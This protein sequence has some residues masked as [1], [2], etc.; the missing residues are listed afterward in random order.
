MS[1]VV[2]VNDLTRYGLRRL[3]VMRMGGRPDWQHWRQMV[4]AAALDSLEYIERHEPAIGVEHLE[5]WWH[6]REMVRVA[7]PPG[8][9]MVGVMWYVER[10]E[11]LS[12]AIE[13][14]TIEYYLAVDRWPVVG[15]YPARGGVPDELVM[16]T[17]EDEAGKALPPL[18][19]PL[20]VA[21]WLP[22]RCIFVA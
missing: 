1:D 16:A 21:A 6:V 4:P 7:P 9:E 3:H 13:R 5:L 19:L 20:Q 12:E 17:G 11:R 10:G 22:E 18:R 14:A 15:L 2:V 8:R